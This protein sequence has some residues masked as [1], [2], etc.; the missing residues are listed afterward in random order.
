MTI[1]S[2][3]GRSPGG[4]ARCS[5]S[6]SAARRRPGGRGT[7]H[8]DVVALPV[9]LPVLMAL[10]GRSADGVEIDDG[11][12]EG[13][14]G[15]TAS[16]ERQAAARAKSTARCACRYHAAARGL[17]V[18]A[19]V[20]LDGGSRGGRWSRDIPVADVWCAPWLPGWPM[21]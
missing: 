1:R 3:G 13:R 15:L 5:R 7:D 11:E 18:T 16:R 14:I 6:R 10:S 4:L 8:F 2:R 12:P 9:H 20:V 19:A 17:A 21:V